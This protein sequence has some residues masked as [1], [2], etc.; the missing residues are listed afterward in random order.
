MRRDWATRLNRWRYNAYAPVY[1]ALAQ[2]LAAR[3]RR[4][5][6]L[7]D[8]QP[9]EALLLLGA[10][11]GLDL[12]FLL[13]CRRIFAIDVSENMLA[14][15]Q[16]RAR[17]LGLAVEAR[18]MDGQRLDYPDASFDAVALHLILAVIPDPQ[19]CLAEVERVLKPGGRAVV[20]DKFLPDGAA[21]SWWRRAVNLPARAL[22][23]DV[24]RRLADIQAAT[25]LRRVHEEEAGFG[26][27]F[28]IVILRK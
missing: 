3:R 7:L 22:A 9:D 28:R 27:F 21:P 5:I 8:P 4:A 11:T 25:A 15:L 20:F 13:R 24:N 14:R 19:A 18:V 17:R 16:R 2:G 12:D 6:A 26:G 10:G 23:T 1:D